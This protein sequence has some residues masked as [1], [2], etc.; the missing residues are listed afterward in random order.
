MLESDENDFLSVA[1]QHE[2]MIIDSG[3]I[4]PIK[5]KEK[6]SLIQA[7]CLNHAILK[8]KAELDQLHQGLSLFGM[9]TLMEQFSSA[10]EPFFVHK[11]DPITASKNFFILLLT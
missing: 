6:E 4:K 5:F 7:I 11:S 1:K 10:L 2:E 8:S 3:Y 9:D